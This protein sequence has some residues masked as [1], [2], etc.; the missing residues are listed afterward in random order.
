MKMT[1]R[2]LGVRSGG[3]RSGAAFR[4]NKKFPWRPQDFISSRLASNKL[5]RE[6]S[7]VIPPITFTVIA[8][9]AQIGA[10]GRVIAAPRSSLTSIDRLY[11]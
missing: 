5:S 8:S 3:Y 6:E 7:D 1:N 9:C 2:Q 4:D 10:P 11:I